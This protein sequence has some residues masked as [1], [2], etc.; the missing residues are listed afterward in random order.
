MTT[1]TK[2]KIIS[3]IRNRDN[4]S[5]DNHDEFPRADWCDEVRGGNTQLGYW[6]WVIHKLEE[7]DEL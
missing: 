6:D 3:V 7:Q 2:A 5:W 1:K 4:G